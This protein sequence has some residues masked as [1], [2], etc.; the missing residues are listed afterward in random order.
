[1]AKITRRKFL[2]G[3]GIAAGAICAGGGIVLWNFMNRRNVPGPGAPGAVVE[4]QEG[5]LQG[6][7]NDGIYRF[8]GV[9]YAQ[10]DER[11]IPARE[12]DHW[13]GVRDASDYG[14]ISPQGSMMGFSAG[15]GANETSNSC[16]NL[17]IWTPGTDDGGLRPV[18]VWLHGG[19]FTTGS[20][21]DSMYDGEALAKAGD[22]VVVTVNHR[23]NI[24]GF[25]D[26]AAY[27]E[28]YAQSANVGIIDIEMALRWIKRN[29][30]VFGGD[31][32]RITI[33]GQSGGGS[34]VLSML[35][36]PSAAGLFDRAICESGT[37]ETMGPV[38]ATEESAARVGELVL[39]NLGIAPEDV[40]RVQDASESDLQSAGD[41]ALAQAAQEFQIPA[42]FASMGYQMEWGPVV[43]G[44]Y[45]P[46]NPVTADGFADASP[47]VP[48]L[49]GSNLNE[50]TNLMGSGGKTQV[51]EGQEDAANEAAAE[52]YPGKNVKAEDVD[53]LIRLPTLRVMSH[54][55]DQG[56]SQ[57]FS[58]IYAY[59]GSN[60]GAEIPAAFARDTEDGKDRIWKA[61]TSFA[62]D[63]VPEADGLPGW[64]PYTRESGA[65]M[66]LDSDSYIAYHHDRQLIDILAPDYQ[67]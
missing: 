28:K 45:L 57:V 21:N 7:V 1:M 6:T 39:E 2:V 41:K 12:A 5:Q 33:F 59:D 34:K 61:W 55:A 46:T 52:A 14:P 64:E 11:F 49:I 67:F 20:G 66:I 40:D 42:P 25:L 36:A 58:Y 47:D 44:I 65:A 56:N 26:L 62:R 16:Q 30:E 4:V 18:M 31:P 48:L 38:F 9:P 63:G 8:L 50:W 29:A 27:R 10:A 13:E 51:P 17:N 3:L 24:F 43:D 54:R 22:A 32:E 60:H 23:L 37:T 15:A 53:M 19:G 35:T